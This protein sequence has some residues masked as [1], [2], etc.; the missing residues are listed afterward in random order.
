MVGFIN[1]GKVLVDVSG[2]ICIKTLTETD[3]YENYNQN[4]ILLAAGFIPDFINECWVSEALNAA[5]VQNIALE[6]G[7][8][9]KDV[10]A[11]DQTF[12]DLVDRGADLIKGPP[13]NGRPIYNKTGKPHQVVGLYCINYQALKLADE[14]RF[15]EK[16]GRHR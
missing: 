3:K 15:F 6:T 4:K 12:L 7:A 14:R 16:Y 11:T 9:L 10:I 1:P 8:T 13:C 5:Y 2:T